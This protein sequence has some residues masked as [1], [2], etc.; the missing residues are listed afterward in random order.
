MAQ[1]FHELFSVEKPIIGMIHLAGENPKEKLKRAL[2]EISI[3]E[4]EGVDG[5]I[6]ENYHCSFKEMFSALDGIIKK[7]NNLPLGINI[8]GS[9]YAAFVLS[10]LTELKFIQVDS[11]QPTD[12]N[13]TLY[14][15]M[16]VRYSNLS[17]LGGIRFK[18]TRPTGNSLE[19]DIMEG[20]SRCEAIVTTGEGTGIETPIEKLEVFR[21]IMGDYPLVVGAGV[22][23]ENV[24]SQ[25]K[26]ADGA[27]VGSYFKN[28]DTRNRVD[29]ERVKDLMSE[30]R[31]LRD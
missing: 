3:F 7:D 31:K 4:G 2:E 8:L 15:K 26:I 27:I 14:D 28:G 30:V 13:L 12:L 20:R 23:A 22:T 6:V 29:K 1:S 25:L 19:R 5:A 16:K 18:Y 10:N 17:V 24:Y 21:E 11:V 9:P